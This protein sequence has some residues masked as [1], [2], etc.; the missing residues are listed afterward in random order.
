MDDSV[1]GHSKVVS[2]SVLICRLVCPPGA[3]PF[4][5]R[6][7]VTA[8]IKRAHVAKHYP[9]LAFFTTLPGNCMAK[10]HR[11]LLSMSSLGGHF[12]V[13]IKVGSQFLV[14]L[15]GGYRVGSWQCCTKWHNVLVEGPKVRNRS[16]PYEYSYQAH[17]LGMPS[18][19]AV[20]SH[21]YSLR[22]T[23]A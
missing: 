12:I 17:L 20:T 18:T 14:P 2:C 4:G 19:P 16:G 5:I 23:S 9:P 1:P 3:S 15:Y 8:G 11:S 13:L 10:G 6:L 21:F 22:I 7:V